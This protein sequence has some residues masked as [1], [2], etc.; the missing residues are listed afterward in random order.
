VPIYEY[1][2]KNCENKFETLILSSD[3][4]I[5]CPECESTTLEKLFSTFGV[6]SERPPSSYP[7]SASSGCGC[8][9]VSCGCSTRH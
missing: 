8:T 7:I 2:C 1:R 5:S 3:E 6:K 4:E 9:P